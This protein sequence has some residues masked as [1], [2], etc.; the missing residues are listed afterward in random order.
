MNFL[1]FL[2]SLFHTVLTLP[3]PQS[4]SI[5]STATVCPGYLPASPDFEFPHLII[6][7][8]A[9]HPTTAYPDT[10]YPTVT[11][12]DMSAIFN[13]DI[14]DLRIGQ[15]CT[16]VFFFPAKSQL[17]TSSWQFRGFGTF[18]FS[19]SAIS[20]GAVEGNTTYNNQPLKGD[21]KGF[22]KS[23]TMQPGNAYIIGS[24]TCVPRRTSVTMSSYDSSLAWFEDTNICPLG[25]YMTYSP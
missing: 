2:A 13:F 4:A 22:P 8:S 3:T 18:S 1:L 15:T 5:N 9:S 7:I 10:Y 21:P 14:P 20:L 24:V 19:F 6:P 25:L 11:A 12:G 23:L 17:A 16:L